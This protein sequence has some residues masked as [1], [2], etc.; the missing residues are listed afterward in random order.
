MTDWPTIASLCTAGGT[1]VLAVATFTSVRSANRAA[2]AAEGSLLAGLRPL[3]VPSRLEDPPEKVGFADEHWVRVPGGRATAEV[4]EE[5]IYLTMALRNVGS[6]IAVLDR[7]LV[8]PERQG[9]TEHE[10]PDQ[11]HRLSRDLYIAPSDRGFWQGALRDPSDPLFA[12][13]RETIE[14]RRAVDGRPAL[15]RLRRRSAGDHP[16]RLPACA[17]NRLAAGRVA[18]LEPRSRRTSLKRPLRR[19][20]AT[21]VANFV[22]NWV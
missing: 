22:R 4:A 9:A 13:M 17:G 11:F 14:A 21:P 7:W 3:L 18:A 6:G 10:A 8:Y 15:Q 2:R 16:L 19:S 20:G 5:A 12:P 1:L